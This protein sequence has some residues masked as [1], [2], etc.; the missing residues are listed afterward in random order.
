MRP[1]EPEH[2]DDGPSNGVAS[3]RSH[4]V[5]L[6]QIAVD[7]GCRDVGDVA[8]YAALEALKVELAIPHVDVAHSADPARFHELVRHLG[9]GSHGEQV[10]SVRR[11]E[12]DGI[13]ERDIPGGPAGIHPLVQ[14]GGEGDP[15]LGGDQLAMSEHFEIPLGH[16]V[17]GRESILQPNADLMGDQPGLLHAGEVADLPSTSFPPVE[18][19]HRVSVLP[20]DGVELDSRGTCSDLHDTASAFAFP[21]H[22]TRLRCQVCWNSFWNFCRGILTWVAI[23]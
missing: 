6:R 1:G 8:P 3:H 2:R 20:I 15:E 14:G 5:E 18:G 9:D 23:H 10:D 22:R 7:V 19:E 4:S 17:P 16:L 13:G 21:G 11:V 12:P